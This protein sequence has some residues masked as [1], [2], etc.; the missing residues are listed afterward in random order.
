V[1][2]IQIC[3]DPWFGIWPGSLSHMTRQIIHER[4]VLNCSQPAVMQ[5]AD[6]NSPAANCS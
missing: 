4:L 3:G 2:L 1:S 6:M 5:L